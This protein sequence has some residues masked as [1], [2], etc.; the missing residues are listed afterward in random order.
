MTKKTTESN[1]I[2]NIDIIILKSD[3]ILPQKTQES[4]ITNTHGC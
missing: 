3:I 2:V 1:N 4:T